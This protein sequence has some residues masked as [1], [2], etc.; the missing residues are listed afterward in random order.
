MGDFCLKVIPNASCDRVLGW[1]DG[2]LRVK[3]QAPPEDGRANRA[4]IA[5][6]AKHFGVPKRS[7]TLLSGEKSREK[8]VRIA[9]VD[10]ERTS[11]NPPERPV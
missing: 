7:I 1:V 11:A 2:V 10:P 4:L 9:G 6:L 5:L 8:R 3:L